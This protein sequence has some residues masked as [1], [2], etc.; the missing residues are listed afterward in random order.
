MLKELTNFDVAIVGYGVTGKACAKFLVD[1]N[2]RVTVFDRQPIDLDSDQLNFTIFDNNSDFSRFRFVVVSPGISPK[3]EA[4][5]RFQDHGGLLISEIELFAW[6]N[7]VPTVGITGSNGKSTVTEMLGHILVQAGYK[8]AIGGNLGQSAISF[9]DQDYDYIVLEL[10][11]FQLELTESLNL[12]LAVLLNISPDHLDRH[13]SMD[14]YLACKQKIFV[15]AKGA[16]CI[17]GISESYPPTSF[18]GIKYYEVGTQTINSA[19]LIINQEQQQ[20]QLKGKALL[21]LDR[22]NVFGLHNHLNALVCCAMALRLGVDEWVIQSA[23]YKFEGLEH[24]T[25]VVAKGQITWVND[26]KATNLGATLAALSGIDEK[27]TCLVLIVGGDA[28]GASIEELS[29]YLGNKVKAMVGIGKD[30]YL[31]E[32]LSKKASKTPLAV[33]EYFQAIDMQDAVLKAADCCLSL[34]KSMATTTPIVLLSPACASI[35][36][37]KN[38]QARGE[39]FA[40]AALAWEA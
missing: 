23:L 14:E 24:R 16:I 32:D 9:L 20:I 4:L 36:M 7:K 11:S 19:D 25:Q 6:F 12:E 30:A 10:S 8:V 37:F 3:H 34:H 31:F 26:S 28:K 33:C 35:D 18:T 22:L 15:N 29:Q 27:T 5:T 21:E 17:N 39:Q 38:Y 13:G 2:A 1:K 40:Q